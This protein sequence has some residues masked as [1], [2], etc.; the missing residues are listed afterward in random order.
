V[1]TKNAKGST[2]K[3]KKLKTKTKAKALP[4]EKRAPRGF[5]KSGRSRIALGFLG[6]V[7]VWYS[8]M[9]IARTV[10]RGDDFL[11]FYKVAQR[12]WD[13]VRPYDQVTFGNMVFKYPPWILPYF[14]P[15]G[16]ADLATARTLWGLIEAG[17]FVAIVARI[18][19]GFA[20]FPS[21]RPWIQGLFLLTLFELFGNHGTTGQITLLVVALAIWADPIKSSFLRFFFLAT[22]LSAK[23][24]SLFPLIYALKRKKL[25]R[26]VLVTG[27]LFFILSLPI[28]FKSYER[29]YGVMR[30]EWTA[31]MFSGTQDVNS[32]RIGFTTRE[33]QGLPSLLLR[34]GG[35]EEKEP[36][37]VLFATALSFLLIGGAWAWFSRGLRPAAQWMGWI[38]L[39]P[40]VQ[41]LA[42]FHVFIFGYPLLVIGAEMAL[43]DQRKETRTWRFIGFFSAALLMGAVNLKTMGALGGELEFAS[44]K[45]WGLLAAVVFFRGAESYGR[46][47]PLPATLD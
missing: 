10:S 32:V 30:E 27:V 9:L 19:Q 17:S 34:K 24:T 37:H 6:L 47:E 41:P 15:F 33:V 7:V 43:R 36:M 25:V 14:L 2:R 42:W 11:V 1:P 5:G 13:G 31:A 38:A 23:I 18:H 45:L 35:L 28:Y 16:F 29:R 21:V 12:F 3:N 20:G 46:R 22:A 44:V 39:L 40:A 8:V 26:T 4:S